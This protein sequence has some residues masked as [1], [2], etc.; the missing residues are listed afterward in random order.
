VP[1][2]SDVVSDRGVE[3]F[4]RF[5]EDIP[6]ADVIISEW[7][8]PGL[9]STERGEGDDAASMPSVFIISDDEEGGTTLNPVVD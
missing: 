8:P 7:R 6:E 4:D 9:R 1:S 5:E 2:P 3:D